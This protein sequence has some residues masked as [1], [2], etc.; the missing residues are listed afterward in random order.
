MVER[1]LE[2]GG[3][4]LVGPLIGVSERFNFVHATEKVYICGHVMMLSL[5]DQCR[6]FMLFV[7]YEC[8]VL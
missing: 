2:D 6:H 7:I 8:N 4:R 5:F 3:A 1:K